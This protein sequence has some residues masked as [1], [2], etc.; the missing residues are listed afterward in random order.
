MIL[1]VAGG[2]RH[3]IERHTPIEFKPRTIFGQDGPTQ[4]QSH[5]RQC[6]GIIRFPFGLPRSTD[7]HELSKLQERFAAGI[8]EQ[9]KSGFD[10]EEKTVVS[11]EC[12]F[13]IPADT[14]SSSHGN[15]LQG[16]EPIVG[17]L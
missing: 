14:E 10:G 6:L 12:I 15:L 5:T 4:P 17:Q 8:P 16:E 7:V 9:W 1:E 3:V 13:A 11:D 2:M